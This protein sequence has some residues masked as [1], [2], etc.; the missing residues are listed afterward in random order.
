MQ[1]HSLQQDKTTVPIMNNVKYIRTS[2]G[3]MMPIYSH[4]AD[5]KKLPQNKKTVPDSVPD[6]VEDEKTL[7]PRNH[8]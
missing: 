8:E 3:S 7:P 4:S 5:N 1:Q 6:S 2:S